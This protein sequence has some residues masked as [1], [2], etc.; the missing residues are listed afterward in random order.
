MPANRKAQIERINQVSAMAR[1]SW[2]ALLGYLA[3]IGVT[4]L[5]VEDADFFVPSRQTQLPLVNVS[6]PTASFF[7][8]APILAAALYIYLHIILLKLWDAIADADTPRIDGHPLGDHL[9]P[10]LVNDW[11]LTRKG[12]PYTPARP[13]LALGNVASFLLVWAAGPSSS[14]ASGG[15]PCPPT[16][17]GSPSSSPP[18]SSSPSMPASPVG[19]LPAVGCPASAATRPPGPGGEV[20]LA[21]IFVLA[22]IVVSWLR[23]E[24]GSDHLA[25]RLIDFGERLSGQ[26][27]FAREEDQ[28]DW[29]ADAPWIPKLDWFDVTSAA[30]VIGRWIK[31]GAPW[32]PLARTDLAGV[33]LVALPDGWRTRETAR[34]AYRE[35]WCRRAGL[36]MAV[37]GLPSRPR[38]AALC[39]TRRRAWR[40]VRRASDL[41]RCP[42]YRRLCLSGRALRL[43]LGGR[44]PQQH[45]RSATPR[46]IR[47]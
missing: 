23:T 20:A 28:A 11:A 36:D 6:I 21:L 37:C 35:A 5:G 16:T 45:R 43:R 26:P 22:T 2:I 14:S 31:P 8:F 24:G 47:P 29:I 38:R 13:F 19:A 44:A 25:G 4:L 27:V 3:F 7:I 34:Q 10:W 18:A 15:A 17:S 32:N 41:P 1:T 40:M 39:I 30:P 46:P 42:L 33:E 12:G 9:N